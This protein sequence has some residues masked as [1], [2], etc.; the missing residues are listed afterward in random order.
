MLN[1][2]SIL[3]QPSQS[4]P[5][6][7]YATPWYQSLKF[8]TKLLQ[9]WYQKVY[10]MPRNSH[11]GKGRPTLSEELEE[12]PLGDTES[13]VDS[14]HTPHPTPSRCDTE[15]MNGLSVTTGAGPTGMPGPKRRDPQVCPGTCLTHRSEGLLT[16]EYSGPCIRSSFFF[17]QASRDERGARA[18]EGRLSPPFKSEKSSGKN[19]RVICSGIVTRDLLEHSDDDGDR[20]GCEKE[21]A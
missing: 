10:H 3:C 12:Y 1:K 17:N 21:A 7:Y 2:C 16:D 13:I 4:G 14:P 8:G 6:E 5:R 15:S 20:R 11:D 9:T 18:G 19:S